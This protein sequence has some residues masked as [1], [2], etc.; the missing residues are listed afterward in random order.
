M[1]KVKIFR[2]SS[3]DPEELELEYNKWLV[4]KKIKIIERKTATNVIHGLGS[5]MVTEFTIFLFYKEKKTIKKP[6]QN[7]KKLYF[8][9]ASA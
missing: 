4:S 2:V 1:E 3:G 9:I 6:I 5:A 7:M 8:L